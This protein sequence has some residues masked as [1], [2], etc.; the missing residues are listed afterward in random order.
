MTGFA[1]QGGEVPGLRWSC[2]ARS[3]NGR[4]LDMRCRLPPS[5]ESLEGP[6]R[7]LTSE[8][9]ARG[10][11]QVTLSAERDVARATVRLN[12]SV[13]DQ[14][15][16]IAD[17][18]KG[19]PGIEAARVDGLLALKG[20]VDV[21]EAPEND[22]ERTAREVQLLRGVADTLD[23]LR[24]AR[25]TEG[26]HLLTVLVGHLDRI[27]DLHAEAE[28]LSDGA[29]EAIRARLREQVAIVLETAPSLD[30]QRLAQEVALIATRSDIKEELDRLKGHIAQARALLSATEPVGRKLDF[31][32]QE[33]NREANTL[34][35]KANSLALTRVGL[36]L[37]AVIDQFRE[38][39]QNVE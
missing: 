13:L 30:P 4:G 27:E 19:L 25:L 8:R 28:A 15:L 17:E 18:L 6:I 26:Q 14:V 7:T 23:R 38:Q 37:K 39:A 31:L 1:R 12:Q 2:E 5:F 33:L 3:V 10:T 36:E 9:F 20:V 22:A 32:T 24:Q 16:R 11:I 34:C 35:S 21:I 29:P